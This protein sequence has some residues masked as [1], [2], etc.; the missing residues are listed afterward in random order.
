MSERKMKKHVSRDI[1][2]R[3]DCQ[4]KVY[5]EKIPGSG[6][7][8]LLYALNNR[9][10]LV[11]AFDG[12]GGAGAKRYANLQGKTGAY[13]ASRVVCG[14]VNDW[15]SDCCAQNAEFS[16]ESL[17][18]RIRKNLAVCD[19]VGGESS[20]FVSSMVKSFPTTAALAVLSD[21]A[22]KIRVD[23]FW[24]GDSRVYLL[25]AD[26][27]AQLSV[28]DLFVTDAMENLYEDGAMTNVISHSKAFTIHHG[29]LMLD[30]PAIV[31]A[32]TDG[33]FGYLP[34]PMAFEQLLINTL[35]RA[36]N[37]DQWEQTLHSVIGRIAGDDYALS[38]VAL[39]FGSFHAMKACFARRA[40]Y[41]QHYYPPEM[42]KEREDKNR[43][44]AQYKPGYYRLQLDK[45]G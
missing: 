17:A 41:L 1:L 4:I 27:L 15:F 19:Q 30:Q 16:T 8:A 9:A 6:E 32:A 18:A 37:V 14:T 44:W 40:K 10:V 13:M 25:N 28:D 23:C 29:S 39:D 2:S 12:C 20:R 26:G 11:G 38:A 5:Q 35:V 22:G 31:F 42:A 21:Q 7:D 43:M 45:N 34:T 36:E 24:A 3:V 33:C